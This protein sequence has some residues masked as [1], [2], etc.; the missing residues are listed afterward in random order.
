MEKKL[1]RLLDTR[2]EVV[3]HKDGDKLNN[4]PDN[5]ELTTRS[6]HSKYHWPKAEVWSKEVG[7]DHE[8]FS[9]IRKPSKIREWSG[10]LYEYDPDNI[11]AN[12]V[13]Y[14][15]VGRKVM[16][17]HLGRPLEKNEILRYKNRDRKDNRVENL[18]IVKRKYGF[19]KS[20]VKYRSGVRKGFGIRNGYAVI[21][22]PEH[23][24]ARPSG[25]ILEHRL[26]MANHLGRMLDRSEHVHHKNGN[27]LDN[28]L[29]NLEVVSNR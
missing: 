2:T 13:G 11:M 15:A 4:D 8:Q 12:V 17:E 28:R 6:E 26:I 5:L 19:K 22:N 21:W 23:P 1:G 7:I 25:Y 29:E 14:V 3:H 9:T 18:E 20:N 10:Y 27:R 24:M 16:A